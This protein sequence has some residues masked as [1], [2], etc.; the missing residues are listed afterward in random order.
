MVGRL[1]DPESRT[2][3]R[4][5][6]R[7]V[8]AGVW[9]SFRLALLGFAIGAAVGVALAA[10]MARFGIVRRGLLPYLVASQTVP[11]IALAPLVVSWS[12]SVHPFG[13]E[14]PR[15]LAVSLL[16][17]FLAFFPVS[18]G[19]AAGPRVDRRQPRSS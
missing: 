15:W 10:L 14:A 1:F 13:L 18:V 3:G 6:W 8:L 17:S 11:L 9:Y 2:S 19:D 16:G 7:V 5:I 12:G 4:P